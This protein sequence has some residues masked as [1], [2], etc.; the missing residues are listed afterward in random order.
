NDRLAKIGNP[1][2]M[3]RARRIRCRRTRETR[4]SPSLISFPLLKWLH[5]SREPVDTHYPPSCTLAVCS[6]DEV[7]LELEYG[8]KEETGEE[9]KE[10]EEKG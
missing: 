9:T 2:R 10:E 3:R 8:E 4:Q 7:I 6:T 5:Q 1:A